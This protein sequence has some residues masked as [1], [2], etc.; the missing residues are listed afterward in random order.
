MIRRFSSFVSQKYRSKTVGSKLISSEPITL[1]G[2]ALVIRSNKTSQEYG[3]DL[4]V[5]SIGKYLM[6]W[7][8]TPQ[9][10]EAVQAWA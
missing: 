9:K 8:F 2:V 10:P 7:G 4:Q 1:I 3:I 5:R 6:R